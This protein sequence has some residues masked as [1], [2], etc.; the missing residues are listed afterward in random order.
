MVGIVG[1]TRTIG[2]ASDPGPTMY[3][4]QAQL[5]DVLNERLVGLT[6]M[7]WVVRTTGDSGALS[8]AIQQEVRQATG[9]AVTEIQSMEEIVSRSTSRRRLGALLIS[10]FGGSA[11]LLAVIGV[12]GL[13]SYSVQQRTQEFGIRLALGSEPHRLR[14]IVIGQGIVLSALGIAAGLIAAFFLV[15]VL[16]AGLY[17]VDRHDPLV[18]TAVPIVLALVSFVAVA[19]PSQRAVAM[20]PMDA[21]RHE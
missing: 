15:S 14:N 2:L 8:A 10:A 11:L 4:P 18:L 5:P 16:A 19:I 1:D 9:V 17:G 20:S 12:Y 6:G 21:L 7:A 3:V 13:T